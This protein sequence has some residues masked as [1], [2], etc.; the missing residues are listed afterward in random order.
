MV[1]L[2]SEGREKTAGQCQACGLGISL[3]VFRVL[4]WQCLDNED[5]VV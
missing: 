1:D 4:W 3:L 5:S 2:A